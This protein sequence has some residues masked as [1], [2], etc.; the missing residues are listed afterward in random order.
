ME[1]GL[2]FGT[3]SLRLPGVVLESLS[4]LSEASQPAAIAAY[5]AWARDAA[6]NTHN[7]H[8]QP[9]S[10]PERSTKQRAVGCE[11]TKIC[12]Y[13]VGLCASAAN[14]GVLRP[15]PAEAL[16]WEAGWR[17]VPERLGVP[18]LRAA[19]KEPYSTP[20]GLDPKP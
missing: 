18:H 12:A 13:S 6:P 8:R 15:A 17:P 9:P 1:S 19:A 20:C 10:S 2:R 14:L 16:T 11:C 3:Q 4:Q 7:P 5:P